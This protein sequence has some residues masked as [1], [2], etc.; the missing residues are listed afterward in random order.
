MRCL[1]A[2]PSQRYADMQ[3]EG[4]EGNQFSYH[5]RALERQRLIKRT[6][7]GYALTAHGII[8]SSG[9]SFET[10]AE[11]IQPKIVTLTVCK[12]N[13]GKYLVYRRGRQPFIGLFGFPYGK[14]HLG[15]NIESAAHR[16]LAEKTGIDA[17]LTQRGIMYH[18]V[19]DGE[20]NIIAHMLFHI[21]VG[22]NVR[23][24]SVPATE[25]GD[26][27]WKTERELLKDSP[28][29]GVKDVLSIIKSRKPGILFEEHE[30]TYAE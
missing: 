15:E 9:V 25:Y 24:S 6:K 16:E 7:N 13:E 10:F 14:I 20:G 17:D 30:A 22:T 8:Y 11:R 26:I 23:G 5:L 18:L 3:P 28:I 1:V 29:P 12:N 27:Y 2:H 21:F 19:R 4:V